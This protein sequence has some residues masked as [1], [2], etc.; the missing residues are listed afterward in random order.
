MLSRQTEMCSFAMWKIMPEI[1]LELFRT[2]RYT[3]EIPV[4]EGDRRMQ[5]TTVKEIYRNREEYSMMEAFLIHFRSYIM[6]RWR[7]SRKSPN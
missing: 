1:G 6:I 4:R 2:M 3:N 5:L 7:I